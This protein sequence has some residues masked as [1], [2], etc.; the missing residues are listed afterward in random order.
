V[1]WINY[2]H[3]LYFRTVAKEGSVTKASKVLSLAQPTISGQIRALEDTLGEKL[4]TR[5]GRNLVLTEFGH[6]VYRY[7]D[8]IF[9]LGKEMADV[10]KGR[11]TGRLPRIHVGV[12]DLLP[13]LVASRILLTATTGPHLAQ[14]V[15]HEDKAE[16]LFEQLAMHGLD[17][18]LSDAPITPGGGIKANN[19]LLG[20]SSVTVFAAPQLAADYKNNFPESLKNAPF[21]LPLEG[22]AIRRE[23]DNWFN[24]NGLGPTVVAEF[25]DSAMLKT[26]G[27]SGAGLF[28]A[29]S[30]VEK[31]VKTT[32]NVVTVGHI[33][34][35]EERFYAVTV[36]RRFKNPAVEAILEA[37]QQ[38]LFGPKNGRE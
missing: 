26:F 15:C 4:F 8:E 5:D 38:K 3:L 1:E 20:S 11:P 33:P 14:L 34:S 12:A 31:D 21:L 10:L 29:P 35:I 25:G 7:A 22:S 23:L 37:A 16:V 13:K 27:Q 19:H 28:V 18:V 9:T 2:H 36:E 24:D 17:L 6:V 32:Y 30:V